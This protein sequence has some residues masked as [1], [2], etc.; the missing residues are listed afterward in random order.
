ML[1]NDNKLTLCDIKSTSKIKVLEESEKFQIVQES[2]R[3]Y[4]VVKRKFH[5]SIKKK[6]DSLSIDEIAK[7]ES[8][9]LNTNSMEMFGGTFGSKNDFIVDMN[10]IDNFRFAKSQHFYDSTIRSIAKKMQWVS[11]N[12]FYLR[13]GASG[14]EHNTKHPGGEVFE[15]QYIDGN[16]CGGTAKS[17]SGYIDN[18]YSKS[19]LLSYDKKLLRDDR[20]VYSHTA[21]LAQND[22]QQVTSYYLKVEC[23]DSRQSILDIISI[24]AEKLELEAYAI[25]LYIKNSPINKNSKVLIKGRVLKHIP[26]KPFTKLQEAAEIAV[27]QMFRLPDDAEMIAVGTKYDRYEPDW[28]AFTNGHKYEARGHLH[29]TIEMEEKSESDILETFH[30]RD[31]WGTEG[32]DIQIILSPIDTIYRIYPIHISNGEWICDSNKEKV[33]TLVDSIANYDS[34]LQKDG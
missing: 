9:D 2:G 14:A 4:L 16:T 34:K 31:V 3:S 26:T 24:V 5:N 12:A 6:I 27:E 22:I 20:I 17:I 11:N 23:L 29:A 21:W 33:K 18:E 15:Y 1:L 28:R 8:I 32:A 30:L 19:I 13:F 25:Q 7:I 10:G